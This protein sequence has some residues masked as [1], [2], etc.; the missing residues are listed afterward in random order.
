MFSRE[1]CQIF[2]NIFL[3]EHLRTTASVKYNDCP[4]NKKSR[5]YVCFSVV[6]VIDEIGNTCSKQSVGVKLKVGSGLKATGIFVILLSQDGF[7]NDSPER[8]S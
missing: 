2:K 4:V 5:D 3:K 8:K 6:T 1:L 7:E